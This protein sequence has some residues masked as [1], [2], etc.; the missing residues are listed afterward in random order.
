MPTAPE[1]SRIL[2]IV[3]ML[4][5]PALIG[6]GI[7]ERL[8]QHALMDARKKG[9]THAE[10]YL[11][12]GLLYPEQADFEA[13]LHMYLQAGFVLIRDFTADNAHQGRKYHGMRQYILQKEIDDYGFSERATRFTF[14]D[15]VI[16]VDVEKTREI[17]KDL[18][19]VNER[20]TCDW[21]AN[22]R[23][24]MEYAHPRVKDFFARLGIDPCKVAQSVAC[25]QNRDGS[26]HYGCTCH[27]CGKIVKGK[28]LTTVQD[29]QLVTMRSEDA[30]EVAEGVIVWFTD[31]CNR[32]EREFDAPVMQLDFCVDLPWLTDKKFPEELLLNG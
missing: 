25:H 7:G 21:C 4:V 17:Y 2:A 14:G 16:D 18:Q 22:Y 11:T 8:L 15:Y 32:V 29:G 19:P 20:C 9:Y 3:D 31:E 27:V 23:K 24:A 5:A 30:Y 1:G 6:S 12:E 10:V 26:W 28:M 13:I